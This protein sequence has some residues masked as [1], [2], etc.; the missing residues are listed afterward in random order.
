MVAQPIK[1]RR[2][3]VSPYPKKLREGLFGDRHLSDLHDIGVDRKQRII[4]LGK[5]PATEN[6]GHS[7]DERMADAFEKN[8]DLL[9][10]LDKKAPILI[11]ISSFGGHYT[12]GHQIISA[13]NECPNPITAIG[14]KDTCSMAALIALAADRFMLRPAA[15][16][17]IHHGYTTYDGSVQLAHTDFKELVKGQELHLQMVIA[18]L[19]EQ[20]KF[21]T[22]SEGDIRAVL[23]REMSDHNDIW[24]DRH[25]AIEW[26]IVDRETN[27]RI[28]KRNEARR[29]KIYTVLNAEYSVQVIAGFKPRPLEKG[30]RP[31]H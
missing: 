7:V 24:L 11:K 1:S 28:T 22:L 27:E 25:Q 4:Y 8:L 14:V 13:I 6:E 12:E 18:R 9:H 29:E 15:K 26:G 23:V 31:W 5:H 20:G 19:K 16:Y 21:N 17:M 30:S 2:P 3:P 10:A